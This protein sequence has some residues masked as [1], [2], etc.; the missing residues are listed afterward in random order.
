M[1][2]E[3]KTENMLIPAFN[4]SLFDSP[5]MDITTE[6]LEVGLDSILDEGLLK[7]IPILG[8]I[9]KT[10][11]LARNIYD[12]NLLRQT[13]MFINSFKDKTIE[14]EKLIKY[15]DSLYKNPKKAEQELGRVLVY[16]NR[17][18]DLQKSQF[19]ASAYRYYISEFY[20]WDQFC[21]LAE[22]VDRL[23]VSDI[24][25]LMQL[26][27]AETSVDIYH[28]TYMHDRLTALG[29]LM[30]DLQRYYLPGE[31]EPRTPERLILSD[32]GKLFCHVYDNTL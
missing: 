22:V 12:R 18:V 16:L 9:V 27:R 30:E 25:E 26:G 23:F 2:S 10:G 14:S 4:S 7:D 1:I 6:L 29:L 19:I 13:F 17:F 21:E 15:R 28:K 24:V 31:D 5:A 11:N 20:S 32:L 3:T 8:V